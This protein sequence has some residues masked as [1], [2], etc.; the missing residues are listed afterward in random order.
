MTTSE[1]KYLIAIDDL[2]KEQSEVIMA[3]VAAY[4]GVARSSCKVAIENLVNQGIIL[5]NGREI[6]FTEE[7][8][9]KFL[10]YNTVVNYLMMHFNNH[11]KTP[12]DTARIDAINIVCMISD[13]TRVGF[14]EFLKENMD[15][16]KAIK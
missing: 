15:R 8:Y 5:F 13:V 6:S 7:G 4:L 3:R 9:K 14:F 10:E 12:L 1:L 11:C 16:K 2:K